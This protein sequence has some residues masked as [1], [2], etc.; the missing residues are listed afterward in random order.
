MEHNLARIE[1]RT[2]NSNL[3]SY[4]KNFK[5]D[6]DKRFEKFEAKKALMTTA[7]EQSLVTLEEPLTPNLLEP[8]AADIF[9]LDKAKADCR[10]EMIKIVREVSHVNLQ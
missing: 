5:I 8:Y 9:G 2:S 3:A 1:T 6:Y 7:R 4:G 10:F